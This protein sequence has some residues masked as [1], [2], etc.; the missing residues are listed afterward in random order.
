MHESANLHFAMSSLSGTSSV[1]IKHVEVG[2][3]CAQRDHSDLS[4][5]IRYFDLKN[6]FVHD[7]RLQSLSSGAVASD[8][9]G[10]NCDRAET[11]GHDIM[12]GMD[13][14]NFT[15]VKMTKAKQIRNLAETMTSWEEDSKL[16]PNILFNPN[17]ATPTPITPS[18]VD[19]GYLLRKVR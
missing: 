8:A 10:I 1:N 15:E 2:K 5:V 12:I 14:V 13:N 9:D 4:K 16:R 19:G 11:V 6:P 3:S 7:S 17:W 18:V